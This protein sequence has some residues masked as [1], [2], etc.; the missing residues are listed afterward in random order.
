MEES[1]DVLGSLPEDRS[2]PIA[3]LTSKGQ[4]TLPKEVREHLHLGQGDRL[5]FVISGSGEVQ[6][7]PVRGSYRAL[8]GMARKPGRAS[9]SDEVLDRE[10]TLSLV[11]DDERIRKGSE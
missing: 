4:V 11:K 1:L 8:E 2:M 7:K 5:E 10:L 6:V 9:P 3:T